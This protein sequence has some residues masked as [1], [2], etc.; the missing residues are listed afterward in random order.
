MTQHQLLIFPR[1]KGAYHQLIEQTQQ[2][3]LISRQALPNIDFCNLLVRAKN[4]G[5]DVQLLLSNPGYFETYS[6]DEIAKEH[7][8]SYD[9]SL[10]SKVTLGEKAHFIHYVQEQGIV[11]HFMNHHKTFLNHSKYMIMD[12]QQVFTGSAPNDHTTRLDMGIV[13]SD[14]MVVNTFHQIFLS[15]FNNSKWH[16]PIPDNITIAPYNLREKIENLLLQAR[17]SIYLMFP[18]V[19]DDPRILKIIQNKLAQGVKVFI[20]CSPD[21]FLTSEGPNIDMQYNEKL[22]GYGALIKELYEPI[23]HNRCILI[24]PDN[25]QGF[26]KKLFLGSGN[27]KTSSLDKSRESGLII[28]TL[29]T[30]TKVRDI[31]QQLWEQ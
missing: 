10:Y 5:V 30:I 13:T 2:Q 12:N 23:I 14:N 24:D 18:V 25:T 28:D 3:L 4:R 11:V 16:N 21:I 31:F 20:L 15:D 1:E 27:L 8:I 9:M 26:S 6:A 19:T 7:Q 17:E 29:G 22:R